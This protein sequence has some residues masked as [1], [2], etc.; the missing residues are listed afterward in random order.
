MLCTNNRVLY[1]AASYAIRVF[2]G[3]D[4]QKLNCDWRG[5]TRIILQHGGPSTAEMRSGGKNV[6]NAIYYGILQALGRD[7]VTSCDMES[8]MRLDNSTNMRNVAV[9]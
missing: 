8:R 4:Y 2:E 9:C 6:E 1:I 3:P 7:G 5:A